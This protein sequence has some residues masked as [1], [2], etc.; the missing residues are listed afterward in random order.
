[1]KFRLIDQ[2]IA[3]EPRRIVA[4][5]NITQSEEYLADRTELSR[6][7]GVLMVKRAA[8]RPPVAR[9][10]LSA[11]GSGERSPSIRVPRSSG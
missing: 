6:A 2:V 5:K 1:M 7:P 9:T 4:V 8:G 3:Q 10:D 11:G